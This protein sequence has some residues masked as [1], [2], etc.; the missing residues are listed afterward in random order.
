[1]PTVSSH[2]LEFIKTNDSISLLRLAFINC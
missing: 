2:I 1:M